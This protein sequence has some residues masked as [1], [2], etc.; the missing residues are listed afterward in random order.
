VSQ[1]LVVH[2]LA[3]HLSVSQ[4]ILTIIAAINSNLHAI[5]CGNLQAEGSFPLRIDRN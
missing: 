3:A 4:D 5:A 1:D 2:S